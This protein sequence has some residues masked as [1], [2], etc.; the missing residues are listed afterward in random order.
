MLSKP[1]MGEEIASELINVI[2]V[3][4][5]LHSKHFLGVMRD[6]VSTSTVAMQ[7]LKIIYPS[8]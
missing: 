2:S 5:G 3:T 6:Q 4:Y 8:L 7:T 1:L